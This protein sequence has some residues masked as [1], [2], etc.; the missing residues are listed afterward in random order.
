MVAYIVNKWRKRQGMAFKFEMEDAVTEYA[1]M[2]YRLAIVHCNS[3]S[4]ADDVFQ[5]VFLKLLKYKHIIKSQEHLK[6]WLLTVTLNQCKSVYMSVWNKRKVS[7]DEIL[8]PAI[9]CESKDY[10]EL[11]KAIRNIPIK[12]RDVIHLFYFEELSIKEISKILKRNEGTVKTQLNRGRQML[13]ECL[14][15]LALILM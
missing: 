6:A 14:Q 9:E 5:E 11:Y 1:D 3:N 10:I 12:Y 8:E 13:K 15:S 2:V 4:D 7:I